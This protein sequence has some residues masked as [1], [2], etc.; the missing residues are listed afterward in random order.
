MI[1]P[2]LFLTIGVLGDYLLASVVVSAHIVAPWN[3]RSDRLHRAYAWRVYT[4]KYI[5][6]PDR[7]SYR[8]EC[9]FS[10]WQKMGDPH[11]TRTCLLLSPICLPR[12]RRAFLVNFQI[13]VY[14]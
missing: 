2:Y 6:T 9:I 13:A 3:P 1:F 8:Y 5:R 10:E 7:W 11:H 14:M 12:Y 4:C